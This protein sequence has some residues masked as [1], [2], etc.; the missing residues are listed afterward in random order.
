[1]EWVVNPLGKGKEPSEEEE[2][3]EGN[4]DLVPSSQDEQEDLTQGAKQFLSCLIILH[5]Y[6]HAF[7]LAQ[8]W[9]THGRQHSGS[10]R[11]ITGW[12]PHS[13]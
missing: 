10:I 1:L 4:M 11:V 2:D 13:E 5:L 8:S 3:D 9:E 6:F 12:V 7:S